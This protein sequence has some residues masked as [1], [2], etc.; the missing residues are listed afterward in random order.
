MAL[1]LIQSLTG[2]WELSWSVQLSRIATGMPLTAAVK[3]G[4]SSPQYLK[5]ARLFTGSPGGRYC[6]RLLAWKEIGDADCEVIRNLKGQALKR[7]VV[8]RQAGLRVL[9]GC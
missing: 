9:L 4:H 3:S 2:T 8:A 1:E 6:V 5:R 7:R